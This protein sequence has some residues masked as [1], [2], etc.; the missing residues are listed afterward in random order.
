MKITDIEMENSNNNE[1]DGSGDLEVK[2]KEFLSEL[3]E[4]GNTELVAQ[5]ALKAL[6]PDDIDEGEIFFLG[7]KIY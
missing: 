7:C 3:L 1:D 2:E 4:A 6:G 5:A